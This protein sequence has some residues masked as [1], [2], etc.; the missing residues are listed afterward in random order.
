MISATSSSIGDT[1]AQM[2]SGS[3]ASTPAATG[4][5]AN[6]SAP[7]GSD[8][9]SGGADFGPAAFVTLSD[10]IKAAAAQRAQSDQAAAERLEAFVAAHRS[11]TAAAAG[12]DT[13]ST[14]TKPTTGSKISAIV[15]QIKTAAGADE[16]Q[17]FKSFTPTSSISNSLS[18][19]GYTLTLSTNANTQY[20]GIKLTGNGIAADSQHFGPSAGEGGASGI[21]PGVTV[22]T[23]MPDPNDQSFDSITITRNV[24]TL[25]SE[26]VSS[27]AGSAS[28]SSVNAQSSS[29]TFL[30]NYASGEIRV[31]Q[32]AMAV[33]AQA[34]QVSAPGSTLSTLA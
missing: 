22:S 19:D 25:S 13:G 5:D 34:A 15:A 23:G 33:S 12:D 8:T 2:I 26:Q 10:Q 20:Y 17:P 11:G 27:S 9:E 7:A 3:G 30:V 21:T 4:S 6:S 28:A 16:P 24:A 1:L 31:Q 14:G 32:S 18:I 29:I